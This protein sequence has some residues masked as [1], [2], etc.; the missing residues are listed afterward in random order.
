MD[1]FALIDDET[2]TKGGY[3]YNSVKWLSCVKS[4]SELLCASL[5]F[6]LL[7]HSQGFPGDGVVVECAALSNFILFQTKQTNK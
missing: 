5:W 6:F 3:S 2:D 1:P 4:P 7:E